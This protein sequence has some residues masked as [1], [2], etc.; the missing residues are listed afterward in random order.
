MTFDPLL[1]AAAVCAAG[2]ALCVIAAIAVAFTPVVGTVFGL[3]GRPGYAK[4]S[5]YLALAL[6]AG[7]A[8]ILYGLVQGILVARGEGRFLAQ[9][10]LSITLAASALIFA[11]AALGSTVAAFGVFVVACWAVYVVG[12]ARI[13]GFGRGVEPEALGSQ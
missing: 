6:L 12:L 7:P 2:A 11:F 13:H 3:L 9:N 1:A 4:G 8:R 5:E 10:S